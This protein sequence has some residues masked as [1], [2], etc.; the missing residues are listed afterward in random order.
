V[1]DFARPAQRVLVQFGFRRQ[2]G[3]IAIHRKRESAFV[4]AGDQEPDCDSDAA[5]PMKAHRD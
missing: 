3:L 1:K 4:Q 2:G 5:P